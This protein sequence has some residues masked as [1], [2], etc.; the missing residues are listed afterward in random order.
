[1]ES[2][3]KVF[4]F[5]GDE[6]VDVEGQRIGKVTEISADPATLAPEWLVVKTSAFGRLR[7]LP[8]DRA[9]DQGAG[10]IRVPFS[11]Q[12]V[13]QA[14]VPEITGSLATSEREALRQYY[15]LAA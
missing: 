8:L 4:H 11:K 1:M 2:S 10:V 14:P 9:I 12:M 7:L 15:H 5:V 6:V 13:L 3:A